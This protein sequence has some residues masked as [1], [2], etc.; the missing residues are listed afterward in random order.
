MKLTHSKIK[1]FCGDV[2]PLSVVSDRD[3]S[4]ESIK[5]YTDNCNVKIRE[6]SDANPLPFNDSVLVSLRAV[7]ET[8]V[9]AEIGEVI[10]CCEVSVRE[11]RRYKKG[12]ELKFFAGD[13]H[14]HT[15]HNHDYKTFPFRESEFPIDCYNQV[16]EVRLLDFFAMSDHAGLICKRDFMRG[17]TDAEMVEPLDTVIFAGCESQCNPADI[18]TD[19]FGI[20]PKS[21]GEVVS[22]NAENYVNA[23]DWSQFTKAFEDSPLPI[24]SFAHPQIIGWAK[25]GNGNF[26]F[27]KINTPELIKLIKLIEMGNGGDR[28]TNAI[29]EYSY[30]VALDCGFKVSPCCTS[31]AHGPKWG[32]S[33]LPGKTIVM[34]PD[35]SKEMLLDALNENRVYACES[36]Q[37]K[38]NFTVNG[39]IAGET[40][41]PSDSYKFHIETGLLSD[42]ESCRPVRCRVISDGGNTVKYMEGNMSSLDFEIKSKSASYF[43]LRFT[44][45]NGRKTWSAPVWTG[46]PCQYKEQPELSPIDKAEFTAVDMST[47]KSAETIINNNP[48][49]IWISETPTPTILIDMKKDYEIRAVGHYPLRPIMG[50]LIEQGMYPN[51]I[52]TQYVSEYRISVSRDGKGYETVAEGLIRVF[53]KEELITFAP[54]SARYVKFEVVSTTGRACELPRY[55]DTTVR[56]GE[57]TIF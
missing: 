19:R 26:D 51:N 4:S 20:K 32:Y 30:S 22:I 2:L 47:G 37:V 18:K 13:L 52:V 38:L 3:I 17:F 36:G 27:E 34:A 53:G 25:Y 1:S 31:D 23:T 10:L 40:L 54:V 42:D 39:C 24:L 50:D 46:R 56:I 7:G 12:D 35:K 28:E 55:R 6:F 29:N 21:G 49:D 11:R 5:W 48:E 8:K 41:S 33:V 9:F 44:D 43:Y 15:S 57:L 14:A 45:I 16:K